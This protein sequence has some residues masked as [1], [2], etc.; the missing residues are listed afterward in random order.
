MLTYLACTLSTY[1]SVC[2]QAC[3]TLWQIPTLDGQTGHIAT[4][5]SIAQCSISPRAQCTWELLLSSLPQKAGPHFKTLGLWAATLSLGTA[6]QA[7][8]AAE[9]YGMSSRA[10]TY[11]RDLPCLAPHSK[12]AAFQV[13]WETGW[14][15]SPRHGICCQ[16]IRMIGVKMQ[17][18]VL[19]QM[20]DDLASQTI[21]PLTTS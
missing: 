13:I 2:S 18:V 21:V 17:Y 6:K 9:P 11:D 5:N 15:S 20:R 14:N 4:W 12:Q 1:S 7:L 16:Q 3:S 8:I 10:Q 19:Y